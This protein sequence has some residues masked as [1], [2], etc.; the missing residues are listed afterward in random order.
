DFLFG[1]R[2]GRGPLGR[3][4]RLAPARLRGRRLRVLILAAP[5]RLGQRLLLGRARRGQIGAALLL[6]GQGLARRLDLVARRRDLGPRARARRLELLGFR[7]AD[8]DLAPPRRQIGVSRLAILLQPRRLGARL[9]HV[10][11][12]RALA[13]RQ[14]VGRLGRGLG[15]LPP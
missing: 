15:L 7:L 1:G 13:P 2:H 3:R 6:V 4:L 10:G 14:R 12:G 9:A 11:L 8:R 5:A